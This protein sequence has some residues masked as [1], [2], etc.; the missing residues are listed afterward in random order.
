M[1]TLTNGVR[2]ISSML[3]GVWAET[4]TAAA[5]RIAEVIRNM[6]ASR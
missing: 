4:G 5:N 1:F 3:A 6:A 2:A